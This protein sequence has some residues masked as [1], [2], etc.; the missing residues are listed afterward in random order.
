VLLSPVLPESTAK[1]WAALGA[2]ALGPL[3]D[4]PIREA[5]RWGQL[6][7]GASVGTLEAL[8]PRIEVAV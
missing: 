5:G 3:Q 8:F 7:E 6:P 2:D 1:L 4:Q